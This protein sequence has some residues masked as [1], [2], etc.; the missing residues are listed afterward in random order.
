MQNS[1]NISG[2]INLADEI[3]IADEDGSIWT[4]GNC[5]N[6]EESRRDGGT[7]ARRFLA[8]EISLRSGT[9]Q[10]GEGQTVLCQIFTRT[11][12][13][14]ENSCNNLIRDGRR[15][16]QMRAVNVERKFADVGRRLSTFKGIV[17]VMNIDVPSADIRDVNL[18]AGQSGGLCLPDDGGT[19][20][21][22]VTHKHPGV[23]VRVHLLVVDVPL[24]PPV[25]VHQVGLTLKDFR[26]DN[27]SNNNL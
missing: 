17:V 25:G 5:D 6:V 2:R 12:A 9:H 21:V 22:L 8:L 4:G 16:N 15:I 27:S 1:K 19:V 14:L 24:V 23:R 7:L 26:E 20:G 10:R 3:V 13:F 18:K 11:V